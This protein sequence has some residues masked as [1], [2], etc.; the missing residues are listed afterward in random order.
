LAEIAKVVVAE[1]KKGP[2]PISSQKRETSRKKDYRSSIVPSSLFFGLQSD[3]RKRKGRRITLERDSLGDSAKRGDS[4]SYSNSLGSL[5]F[6]ETPPPREGSVH[7][8]QGRTAGRRKDNDDPANMAITGRSTMQ[9]KKQKRVIM[10]TG[11]M[12]RRHSHKKKK[13]RHKS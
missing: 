11:R 13:E 8:T 7:S 5:V 12:Y 1:R 10:T 6:G 2:V 4:I 3:S 9:V